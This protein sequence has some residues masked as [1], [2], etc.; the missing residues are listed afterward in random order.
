MYLMQSGS[1]GAA[2]YDKETQ[3]CYIF[4]KSELDPDANIV[5]PTDATKKYKK[6][7][8]LNVFPLYREGLQMM[9]KVD[10]P[11]HQY[12]F[13]L[14]CGGENMPPCRLDETTVP[15]GGSI[16]DPV[17]PLREKGCNKGRR[18][19]NI[20]SKATMQLYQTT[21]K[22]TLPFSDTENLT[23]CQPFSMAQYTGHFPIGDNLPPACTDTTPCEYGFRKD[24]PVFDPF[25][26]APYQPSLSLARFALPEQIY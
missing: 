18:D 10:E 19:P 24:L 8:F 1:L 14:A 6:D 12:T 23:L 4:D 2:V 17:F 15:E 7:D 13:M 16:A 21:Y 20:G 25:S 5:E 22:T 11:E 9:D 26:G 3:H